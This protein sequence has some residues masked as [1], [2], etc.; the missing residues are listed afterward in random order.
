MNNL[1]KG[2]RSLKIHEQDLGIPSGE[3][4][5]ISDGNLLPSIFL[6]CKG[7]K[8]LP[9]LRKGSMWRRTP[10]ETCSPH[11]GP[12]LRLWWGAKGVNTLTKCC[13][14]FLFPVSSIIDQ[15]K[16]EP[17]EQKEVLLQLIVVRHRAG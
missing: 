2:Q 16:P 15:V 6:K 14:V 11:E 10:V 17:R 12:K 1:I 3:N 9:E 13:S 7:K 4:I 5:Y 8:S